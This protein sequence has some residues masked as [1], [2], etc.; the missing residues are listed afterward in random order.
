LQIKNYRKSRKITGK[1]VIQA[2]GAGKIG[3][4]GDFPESEGNGNVE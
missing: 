4:D 1:T 2:V 3:T